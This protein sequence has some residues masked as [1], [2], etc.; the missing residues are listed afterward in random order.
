MSDLADDMALPKV[1][2]TET[3]ALSDDEVGRLLAAA[4]GTAVAVPLLCL[5]TLVV[6]RG[7]L[8]GLT[9]LDVDFAHAQLAIRRTIEESSAGLTF[10]EPRTAPHLPSP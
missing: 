1:R 6:R 5:V 9:W 4:E 10:K 2:R 3:A 8:L 7:E